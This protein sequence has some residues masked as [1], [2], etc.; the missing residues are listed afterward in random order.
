MTQEFPF[1]SES[2]K[3]LDLF[4]SFAAR[5]EIHGQGNNGFEEPLDTLIDIWGKQSWASTPA[6][7][8]CSEVERKT[9]A[10]KNKR[11]KTKQKEH[12]MKYNLLGKSTRLQVSSLSLSPAPSSSEP[13]CHT[14][15][16]W[17]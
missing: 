10:K 12:H 16:R 7:E 3:N 1:I 11:Q 17:E 15:M 2:T 4:F 8:I 13:V 6:N 5:H 14:I 9:I